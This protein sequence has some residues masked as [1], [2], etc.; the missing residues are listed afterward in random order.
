[1]KH[2]RFFVPIAI[3]VSMSAFLFSCNGGEKKVEETSA[4][5]TA[6]AP[7]P[8][9]PPK[10]VNLMTVIAKVANFEK[11]LPD[12]E[13]H[14]SIRQ[15]YGLH[16]FSIGR[17]AKDSNMVIVVLIMD[18]AARAKEFVASPD[19]K[20]R[21]KKGGVVGPPTINF[22]DMQMLDI[23]PTTS[24][25]LMIKHRV[26]DYDAWKKVFDADK[27]ARIDSG[28]TNRALGYEVGD[29][30]AVTIVF[31]VSDI[32]KADA[33][34]KSEALKKKMEEGGVEGIPTMFYYNQVKKY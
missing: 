30:H 33:F 21:M 11:W 32:K 28:F 19:L 22:L 2:F 16:N 34:S 17:G 29:N 10:P 3:G 9:A 24:T 5:T 14:D 23:T 27:Q 31:L 12:Y 15:S 18:D 1:M 26:K 7:E 25:R 4:D 6:V 8:P 20:A 13:S